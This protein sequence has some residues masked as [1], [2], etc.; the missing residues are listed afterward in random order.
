MKQVSIGMNRYYQIVG[1]WTAAMLPAVVVVGG[2]LSVFRVAVVKSIASTPHPELVYAILAA[3]F[4]GVLLTCSTLWRYTQEANLIERWL[5]VPFEARESLVSRLSHSYV[6]PVYEILLGKRVVLGEVR[7][8][9]LEQEI[10]NVRAHLDDRL[11][12]PHYLA[13]ALVGLGLVGTF[14]GL[15][16]TLDDLGKLFGALANTDSSANANPADIF[17]DMVRR[18]QDPMRGMGTA[19]VA[20]LYGLLGSLVLG[21]QILV[22][23]RIGHNLSSE[24][25]SILRDDP[26]AQ[27]QA[28]HAPVATVTSTPAVAATEPGMA[29]HTLE[30]VL[31]AAQREQAEQWQ[32]MLAKLL[33]HQESRLLAS[34]T[35]QSEQSMALQQLIRQMRQQ[36]D[37][38]VDVLHA[39]QKEQAQLWQEASE[40]MRQQFERSQQETQE[41]KRQVQTMVDATQALA[42]AVRHNGEAEARFRNSVPRTHYWQD[43]WAKVQTYLQRSANDQAINDMVE[44]S[45]EQTRVLNRL[46]DT[47]L[48]M[49]RR[50]AQQSASRQG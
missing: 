33:E 4:I 2:A 1:Q 43:A 20:S 11:A 18:L 25:H 10:A 6:M 49:D 17:A 34:H 8:S 44:V 39:L 38:Q 5:K 26:Q 48:D 37:H 9:V 45:R 35:A 27:A 46:S 12:L 24:L 30:Q 32:Q 50:M 23:G 28:V 15:L 40:H 47:L 31:Q 36:H 19:F 3:F 14:V 16:G 22:V 29:V 42:L 7:Q 21:L 13:G 41:L